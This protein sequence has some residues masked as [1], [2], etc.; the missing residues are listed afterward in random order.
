MKKLFFLIFPFTAFTQGAGNT[1][2][3]TDQVITLNLTFTQTAFWDSLTANYATETDMIAAEMEIIDNTGTHQFDSINIRLK[4]NSSY[5]HPGNKKSFKIDFND[6]VSG[7]NY[8]GMKK[9]NF[10]N[11]F[12]DPS[13]M[14]SKLFMDISRVAGV[15]SP[16]V[17]YANVYMNGTFWGFY[18]MV[19]QVDKEFIQ[20]N[21]P[22]DKGNLFKAG[23]GF[24][25][26]PVFA[27]LKD[28][29]TNQSAYYDRYELKMNE[30]TNDWTDLM[31]LIDFIN[32][33]STIDFEN[34][35]ASNFNKTA[36]FRSIATD[37]LF[38][39][40]DSYQNSA[41]NYYIYHDS[42]NNRWEWIKWDGN[43]AFGSYNP[44]GSIS[45]MTQMA[46]N[47]VGNN[48]PLIQNIFNNSTLYSEYLLELCWIMDQYFNSSYF[49]AK[50]DALKNLI[51][52]HVYADNNKMY[53]NTQFDQ[54]IE[55]NINVGGMGGG[56]V[57]G[58]KSFVDE[59]YTY[60]QSVV[61]CSLGVNENDLSSL[62]AYPNPFSNEIFLQLN[63]IQIDELKMFDLL[64]KEVSF[65]MRHNANLLEIN[66]D[67]QEGIYFLN[68][69]S[70]SDLQIIKLVKH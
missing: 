25:S 59:R 36:L 33:S 55:N 65:T 57:Y 29:G 24:G 48:R 63:D 7:Q 68:I 39:N 67:C 15:P 31:D 40:L 30:S 49:D 34:N 51:A 19:E 8:D 52:T 69:K 11:C 44:G 64:G 5:G 62:V 1:V 16:R 27:D 21:F 18:A 58:L 17:N 54:N 28:Y 50:A 9:L 2:Y 38:S 14:R 42:V 53:S 6:Y 23:D 46:A 26:N 41:R 70:G 4:G 22:D 12:K 20:T 32:N 56:N 43:E 66:A 10:D 60:L 47:Y 3:G 45:N 61:D 35:L 37:V 13:F